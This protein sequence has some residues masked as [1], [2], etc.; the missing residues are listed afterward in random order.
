MWLPNSP[1]IWYEKNKVVIS[2]AFMLG[3]RVL[4]LN[5]IDLPLDCFSQGLV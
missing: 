3:Y 5:T 1:C 4:Y 2:S